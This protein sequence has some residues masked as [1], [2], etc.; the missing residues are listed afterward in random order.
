[1]TTASAKAAGA[2]VARK[3]QPRPC[4]SPAAQ[5]RGHEQQRRD[6]EI[7]KQQHR[8]GRA[9]DHGA[10]PLAFGE[11]RNHDRRRGERKGR[12][13]DERGG[14][15]LAKRIGD[16]RQDQGRRHDLREAEPEDEPAH[17]LQSFEGQFQPHREQKGHD[18]EFG[19]PA[20][21]LDIGE[22]ERAQPGRLLGKP[23]KTVRTER[24]PRQHVSEH[25]ADAQ[26][27]EQRRHHARRHQEQQ[28]FL[29]SREIEG[30]VQEGLSAAPLARGGLDVIWLDRQA[31][32]WSVPCPPRTAWRE[33]RKSS[34][35]R[36]SSR[37]SPCAT[38]GTGSRRRRRWWRA[39]CAR[40][41]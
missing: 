17:R 3:A 12:A 5:H 34:P 19:H 28:R 20:D 23:A 38:S 9:A 33:P 10:E 22:G 15:R 32:I 35:S 39:D 29:I 2:S 37:C 24:Q 31:N 30:L 36:R 27:E 18:A 21:R 8:K 16:R 40:S 1:M 6:G 14:R 13:D 7:L 4:P 25:R 11:D 26:P 41:K